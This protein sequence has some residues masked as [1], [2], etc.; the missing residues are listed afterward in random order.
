MDRTAMLRR[1]AIVFGMLSASL[2][3]AADPFDKVS[4]R[5]NEK[6]L[7]VFGAGGFRGATN[8]STGILVSEDGHFLTVANQ[9][10]DTSELIVHLS[11]GRRVKASV[12]VM[13]PE[14]DVAL[15]QIKV[16]GKKVGE[17]TGL[18]LPHF[19]LDEEVKKK[20]AES[21]DWVL[22]Y[23]NLFEIAMRDEAVSVMQ[24]T[25]LSYSKL[26]GRR[27]IFDFPYTGDVYVVDAITNGPG[28][29][30]GPLVNRRGDLLGIIGREIKNSLSE[31]WINYAIPINATVHLKDGDKTVT[32][33]IAEF[34]SK[35]IKGHYKPILKTIATN[36]PGGFTGIKFVPNILDRT[37]PYVDELTPGSPAEKAGV[38]VNDLVSF[39]DGEPIYS[40][41]TYQEYMK[42]TR[43]DSTIRVEVRR[44]DNLQSIELKLGE[45]PKGMLKPTAATPDVAP[46]IGK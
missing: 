14:L 8:Y 32:V 4:S 6:V 33:S 46:P 27:G 25:I 11:D 19:K 16:D 34:S 21:G 24:G 2:V 22:A 13:E 15:C 28:A 45:W 40:I 5:V 18:K 10:L 38:M 35:G 31:T 43:P 17:S 20:P 29:G 41:K 37:P 3:T 9:T 30:G 12:L 44:G 39:I 23:S 26:H 36:G 42:R 7:K 1:F